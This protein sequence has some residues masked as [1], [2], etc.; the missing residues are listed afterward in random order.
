MLKDKLAKEREDMLTRR[1]IWNAFKDLLPMVALIG[2]SKA[3][4][5]LEKTKNQ[6]EY[7]L[8]PS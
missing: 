7:Y 1:L 5:L 3:E 8:A 6:M 4:R 2:I